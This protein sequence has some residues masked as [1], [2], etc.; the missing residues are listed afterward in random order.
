[1]R[2]SI[3]LSIRLVS[4]MFRD[5]K[6]SVRNVILDLFAVALVC[7]IP[8]PAFA[9]SLADCVVEIST[10]RSDGL[11]WHGSGIIVGDDKST[12]EI[13]TVAHIVRSNDFTV[14]FHSG[15]SVSGHVKAT[16]LPGHDLAF[17]NLWGVQKRYPVAVLGDDSNVVDGT[18][19]GDPVDQDGW[20]ESK[21]T[22]LT[23]TD[24]YI[25]YTR[26]TVSEGD[27]G[28]PVFNSRGEVVSLLVA[29]GKATI[30]DRKVDVS[31]GEDVR[32]IRKLLGMD[33]AS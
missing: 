5:A 3:V 18:A 13:V 33:E 11:A 23:T 9:Q 15:E 31:L 30:D 6:K 16:F 22:Y 24:S 4:V 32:Y 27:S 20:V 2:R 10:Q 7:M 8:M 1:M 28:A 21:V 26:G 19:I 25:V 17:F 14:T 29:V 12:V